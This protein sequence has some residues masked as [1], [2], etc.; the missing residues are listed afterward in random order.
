M[1]RA[2]YP[3]DGRTIRGWLQAPSGAIAALSFLP[4]NRGTSASQE[5]APVRRVSRGR[6]SVDFPR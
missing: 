1:L 4:S 3:V 2:A 6:L 5:F